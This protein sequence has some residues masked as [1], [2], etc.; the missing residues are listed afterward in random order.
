MEIQVVIGKTPHR[1]KKEDFYTKETKATKVADSHRIGE[2]GRFLDRAIGARKNETHNSVSQFQFVEID[3]QAKR[4][5][6]KPH[7]TKQLRLMHGQN[8]LNTFQLEQETI[9]DQNVKSQGLV[10]Y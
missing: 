9:F 7:I 1:G 3:N 5:V 2:L 8:A 4:D 10:K 6:E